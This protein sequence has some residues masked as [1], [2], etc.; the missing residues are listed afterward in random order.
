[1]IVTNNAYW[2]RR[3]NFKY[4]QEVRRLAAAVAPNAQSI[5][6]VGSNGCPYLDWWQNAT[7][8]VSVDLRRPYVAPGVEWVV[9]DFLEYDV[10]AKF[11]LCLCLQVLEHVPDARSMARK[12]LAIADHVIASVPYQWPRG[13]VKWHVH[14]PV[15]EQKMLDWFGREP[16]KAI[17]VKEDSGGK[18]A[19][20]L[21]CYYQTTEHSR[22][23]KGLPLHRRQ[24]GQKLLDRWKRIYAL[25]S[26][27]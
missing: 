10:D 17:I 1:M 6:D 23:F 2:E 12:L 25:A 4:L 5:V 18:C 16:D 9:G 20:R 19:R 15:D 13:R 21:I 3:K 26:R 22:R 7:R 24:F 27:L 14:D 11:D 8:R